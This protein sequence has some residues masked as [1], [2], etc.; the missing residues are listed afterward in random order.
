MLAYSKYDRPQADEAVHFE[1]FKN[2]IKPEALQNLKK[3]NDESD[4]KLIQ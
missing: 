1:W 3:G 2:L 4:F